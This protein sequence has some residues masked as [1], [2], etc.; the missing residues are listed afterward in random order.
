LNSVKLND[1]TTNLRSH[2]QTLYAQ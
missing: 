2:L 1:L